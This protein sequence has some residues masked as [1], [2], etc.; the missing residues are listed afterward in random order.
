MNQYQLTKLKNG[1]RLMT[2][3]MPGVE[4]LTVMIGVAAGSRF[5][6][7]SIGG[8]FHFLEHMAFKGTHKRPSALSISSEIDGVGGMFNAFTDKELTAYHI[9]LA[10]KHQE[11]AFDI[12]SDMLTNSLFKAEEIEREKGVIIEEINMYEDTPIRKVHEVFERLIY[13]NNPMGWSIAGTKT[14]VKQLQ[15]KDFLDTID[16]LYFAQNMALIV[17]GKVDHQSI[18]KMAGQYFG[19]LNKAGKSRFEPIKM[20]QKR[21]KV[22]LVTKKTEQAHFC[23]GVPGYHYSHPDRFT[24][25]VLAAVLGGGMSSRLFIQIRERRG[26]AYYTDCAPDFHTDSGY[27]LAKAGVRLK[28]AGEAIEVTLDEFFNLTKTPVPNKELNKAKELL[29]GR[30]ILALEDSQRVAGRYAYQVLLKDKIRTPQQTIEEIDKVTS[31]DV[32]RVAKAVFKPQKLNL[33]IVGPYQ[34][35]EKFTKLLR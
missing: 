32:R 6:S 20:V 5:E 8:I 25:G 19:G 4:S 33:A 14:T 23:L 30:M 3:P 9:K 16:R 12:I 28:K 13:G 18:K 7:K 10:S 27:L 2:V 1:L 29:K 26:L 17:A 35:R 15:K 34:D 21:S 24:L 11:L 22:K 31:D